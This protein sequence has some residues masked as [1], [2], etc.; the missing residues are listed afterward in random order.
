M[1][2]NMRIYFIKSPYLGLWGVLGKSN[3]GG[4]CVWKELIRPLSQ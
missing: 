1:S 2:V 4:L 3:Q